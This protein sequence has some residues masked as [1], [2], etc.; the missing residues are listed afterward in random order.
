MM[1]TELSGAKTQSHV[2]AVRLL[3][4]KESRSS[5]NPGEGRATV[6]VNS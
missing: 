1:Q 3:N 6:T 5:R 2:V 4:Y